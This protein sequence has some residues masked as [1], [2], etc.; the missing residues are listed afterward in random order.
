MFF[1]LTPEVQSAYIMWQAV[2]VMA[3][4]VLGKYKDIID[5]Y[6][7]DV[8]DTQTPTPRWEVCVTSTLR[9]FADAL[10]RPFVKEVYDVTAKTMSTEMIKAVKEVFKTNLDSMEW[11]DDV[12]KSYAKK[13]AS[14]MLENIGYPE[15]IMNDT[16][17]EERYNG[18]DIINGQ[19]FKNY[20]EQRKFSNMK[21][22][23]KRG[24]PVD[25]SEWGIPPTDVNA[26][27]APTENKIGFTAGI[28][29]WPFYDK[30]APRALAYGA[31]GMVVGHEISHG[32]D[33]QGK[34][35]TIQGNFDTWWT[36]HSAR[37]FE[38]KTKCFI[39]QYSN[40]SMFG[41]NI[42][43][44]QTL[45]EN[46]ADNGGLR[47]S[48]QA[49]QLWTKKNGREQQLPGLDLTPEQLF[50]LAFAQ[51]WCTAYREP[52]AVSQ[53]ETGFHTLSNFRVIGTLQN[54]KEFSEA[55]NCPVGSRMN[56][57]KKC[58]IW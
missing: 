55:Y 37:E 34:D 57:A 38:K 5:E 47:Q 41:V 51:V 24:K 50:F 3:P 16:A 10:S 17:L 52:G 23:K 46:L 14:L 56:P 19:H 40:F 26:Y 36:N 43:G 9:V 20:M 25:K 11:M 13:K 58:Q 42:K 53:I 18:L 7:M 22:Y 6:Q 54:S 4:V 35:F 29:Q 27:Y 21:N 32:F 15:F 45:G 2:K 1:N 44:K 49:Y 31:I 8:S 39:D 33:D 48:Y 28:L 30:R 12:T